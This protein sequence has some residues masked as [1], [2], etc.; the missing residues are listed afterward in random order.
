MDYT[1]HDENEIT[2]FRS[3]E[4]NIY[5]SL[6]APAR[7]LL[8]CAWRVSRPGSWHR[9]NVAGRSTSRSVAMAVTHGSDTSCPGSRKAKQTRT[10]QWYP[11]PVLGQIQ[12][13]QK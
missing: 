9:G 2:L 11:C 12:A 3:H 1:E 8:P 10:Y 5:K 13:R 6:E 7:C 4:H